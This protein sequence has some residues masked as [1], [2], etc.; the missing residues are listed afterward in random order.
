MA[1]SAAWYEDTRK[2][3]EE[4]RGAVERLF[5][6]ELQRAGVEGEWIAA[7]Q[8]AEQ[9]VVAHSRY[10]DLVIAGQTHSEDP[11]TYI[12]EHFPE[13]IVMESGRPLLLV[14]YAGR[15]QSLG[16]RALVAWNGSREATRAV[17]DAMPLLVGAARVTVLRINT[18]NAPAIA[19]E[20]GTDI[21]LTLAR[22]GVNVDFAELAHD[23]DES[24]GDALLSWAGGNGYDL[25]V[26][27]AYGHA[28]WKERVLGGVTRTLFES[29]TLPVL[30]S[31]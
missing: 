7:S 20:P 12:A 25:L 9:S 11:E 13:T 21:V 2:L 28:R 23:L 26:M 30:M 5:R 15:F 6:A 3:H 22:H 8:N 18:P 14:P 27:G 1:G 31:H 17:H 24:S 19:R 29:A 10:A 16:T 4:R